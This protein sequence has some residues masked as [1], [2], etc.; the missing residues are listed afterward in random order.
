M[1]GGVLETQG[2]TVC[3]NFF[4]LFAFCCQCALASTPA[5]RLARTPVARMQESAS[6]EEENV[7]ADSS[8]K[9]L[10]A[11]APKE[12]RSALGS[13]SN[14][15]SAKAHAQASSRHSQ[16]LDTDPIEHCTAP[17]AS[18]YFTAL[19]LPRDDLF[20]SHSHRAR[21]RD[22]G[23]ALSSGFPLALP[24]EDLLPSEQRFPQPLP[25]SVRASARD[26]TMVLSEGGALLLG[27]PS[28]GSAEEEE[29]GECTRLFALTGGLGEVGGDA[30]SKA[31]ELF[32]LSF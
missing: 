29:D 20:G 3:K 9:R 17:H 32:P 11:A 26:A 14:R 7:S 10:N 8:A 5:Q 16:H 30:C 21:V 1:T 31:L 4:G 18:T 24:V 12:K 25:L 27:P 13:I 19:S 23:R 15:G 2:L 22:A 28:V 6:K